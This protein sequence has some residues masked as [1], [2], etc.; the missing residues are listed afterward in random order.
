M[1]CGIEYKYCVLTPAHLEARN[2]D[3][4]VRY[5][6]AAIHDCEMVPSIG[7]LSVQVHVRYIATCDSDSAAIQD[8]EMAIQDCE[9]VT[10]EHSHNWRII[11][12]RLLFVLRFI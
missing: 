12:Q 4:H 10:F 9:M 3:V 6:S 1:Y 11:R 5:H 2:T 8:C 7:V